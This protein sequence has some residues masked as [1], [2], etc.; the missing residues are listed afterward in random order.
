LKDVIHDSAIQLKVG[1]TVSAATATTGAAAFLE[2]MTPIMGFIASAVG[3][4][5]SIIFIYN[6]IRKNK[7][8]ERLLELKEK[9]YS[10]EQEELNNLVKQLEKEL[11]KTK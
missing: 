2:V 5:L 6:A 10:D 11:A 4:C 7:R 3:I 9:E 1:A 8:E